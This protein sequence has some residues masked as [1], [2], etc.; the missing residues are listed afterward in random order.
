M[1]SNAFLQYSHRFWGEHCAQLS[2]EDRKSLGVSKELLD[3][4]IEGSGSTTFQDWLLAAEKFPKFSTR[5]WT[6]DSGSPVFSA[7][8]WNLVEV[9]EKLISADPVY[10]LN[11]NQQ[12]QARTSLSLAS[13]KGYDIIVRLLLDK[14]VNTE[15][16]DKYGWTP[17][18]WAS[19][20]GHIEI[21]QLLL[22]RGA[23]GIK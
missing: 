2:K 17:L 10:H 23:E 6:L 4:I 14:G 21:V 12:L 13:Y 15:A 1:Q 3:W 16:A 19:K 5:F 18:Y 11:L 8:D 7:C 20:N 9:L 22:D